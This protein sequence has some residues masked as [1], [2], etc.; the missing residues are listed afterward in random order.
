MRNLV[1]ILCAVSM[2]GCKSNDSSTGPYYSGPAVG[3]VIVTLN[4]SGD[5]ST[6]PSAYAASLDSLT[7][8]NLIPGENRSVVPAGAHT[9]ALAGFGPSGVFAAEYQS[10][11][12]ATGPNRFSG[13]IPANAIT[14]VTFSVDCPPLVGNGELRLSYTVSGSNAATTEMQVNLLRLNGA[15]LRSA[16]NVPSGKSIDVTLPVGLYRVSTN[17]SGSCSPSNTYVFLGM[18]VR[19]VREGTRTAVNFSLTCK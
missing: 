19:A 12:A 16:V 15:T 6:G 5:P 4:V 17:G 2:L 1:L 3:D 10:W 14:V 7:W 13:Q 9:I 11:C 8:K 18:P